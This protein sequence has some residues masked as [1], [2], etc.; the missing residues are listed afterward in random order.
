MTQMKK[1]FGCAVAAA[2]FSIAG[3]VPAAA[4]SAS[5]SAAGERPVTSGAYSEAQAEHGKT[6]FRE[7]CADC[8]PVAQFKG[9]PFLRQWAGRRVFDLFDQIR[10]TMPNTNPGALTRQQYADIVAYLL[11]ENALPAGTTPL[12]AGDDELKKIR[13]APRAAA[14]N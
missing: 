13:F 1:W 4:Q 12:P 9:A 7:Q 11:S 2:A 6:L 14:G 3:A 5:G 8:H 10:T